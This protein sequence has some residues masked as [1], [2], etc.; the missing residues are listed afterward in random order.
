MSAPPARA[1]TG[2]LP[3]GRYGRIQLGTGQQ[4][5]TLHH[6]LDGGCRCGRA[7]V[8]ALAVLVFFSGM[9]LVGAVID[10]SVFEGWRWWTDWLT[11]ARKWY[12]P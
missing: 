3:E 5:R 6:V 1:E 8:I 7:L 12:P 4:L 2:K 10:G 9:S 11:G